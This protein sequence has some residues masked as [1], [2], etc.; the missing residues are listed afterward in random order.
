MNIIIGLLPGI[1]FALLFYFLDKKR[2]NLN[3]VFL[4]ATFVFGCLS[5]YLAYRLEWHFGSY[6]K[7]MA[8]SNLLEVFIYALFGVAI[9]E[10]G[11]KLFFS[12]MFS[13]MNKAFELTNIITYCVFA[14]S[15]FLAFENVVFYSTNSVSRLFTASPSHICC[16]I[17]MGVLLYKVKNIN[18]KSFIYLFLAFIIPSILHAIYNTFLYQGISNLRIVNIIY[19]ILLVFICLFIVIRIYYLKKD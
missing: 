6:F 15:G 19:L 11:L 7:E 12:F 9:F 10:E 4:I 1:V 18:W 13:R 5:S 14:S 2:E 3:I 17:I 16:A 8:D